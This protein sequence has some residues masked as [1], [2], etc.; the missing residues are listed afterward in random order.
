[1]HTGIVSLVRVEIQ[2]PVRVRCKDDMKKTIYNTFLLASPHLGLRSFMPSFLSSRWGGWGGRADGWTK[3]LGHER[4]LLTL[5]GQDWVSFITT[6]TGGPLASHFPQCFVLPHTLWGDGGV[7]ASGTGF[8][9]SN[10]AKV[11]DRVDQGDGKGRYG[12]FLF[13][14]FPFQ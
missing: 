10:L 9:M 8:G 7:G 5:D 13:L 4:F 12:K 11:G 1:M 6:W 3:L 2:W 14:S